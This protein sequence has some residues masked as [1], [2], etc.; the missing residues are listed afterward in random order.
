MKYPSTQ[1]DTSP[2]ILVLPISIPIT[3][4]KR[5]SLNLN[6]YRNTHFQVLNKAKR[7][8]TEQIKS[9]VKALPFL[10]EVSLEYV[11]YPKSKRLIDIS[12]VCSIVDKF[13][14]DALTE[15]KKIEDDNHLFVKEI[16]Y[17]FGSVDTVNPRCEVHIYTWN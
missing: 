13:F 8:F 11:L 14:C 3:K 17:S 12:N 6:Q 9:Q 10:K 2:Y 15:Y 4:N 1:G 16:L 7:L 5:F